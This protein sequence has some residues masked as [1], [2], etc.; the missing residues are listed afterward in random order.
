[1]AR[2]LAKM[3]IDQLIQLPEGKKLEFKRDLSSV[4]PLMKTLVAFAN[5]A[6]GKLIIGIA[7][8]KQVIGVDDPLTE[9]ERLGNLVA[10]SITPRLVPSIEMVTIESKTL[11]IVE[12]YLSNTR[13]HWLTALGLERGVMVRLGSSNRQAGLELIADLQRSVSNQYFDEMP[14][15]ELTVDDLDMDAA[16]QLF[17]DKRDLNQQALL[18]LKLLTHH[19]ARLVPTK[20]A[21]LLFGKQRSFYFNDAWIQCGRFIGKDRTDIFDHIELYDHLPQAADSIIMF[22]KKHAMRGSDFSELRR[23]DVWSIPL[24]ILREVVINAL[25]HADYSQRGMP[26]RVAFY[27]DRIEIESSG[28][29]LPGM[30]V[31]DMKRGTSMIRNPI[32]ARVFRELDLIEQWG[33]GVRGM[34][35]EA[36][37]LGLPEPVIEEVA[38]RVR[39]TVWLAKALPVPKPDKGSRA[40]SGAQSWAQ[41]DQTPQSQSV[42]ICQMLEDQPLSASN[43]LH[44]LGLNSKTGAFKRAIKELLEQGLIEYTIPDKPNSRLQKYRLTDKG[45]KSPKDL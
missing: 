14:M 37:Q 44:I 38:M 22:L 27:D 32:I 30:T 28:L 6:G 3:N 29:L 4:K 45:L 2:P 42:L 10:D 31:E 8:D 21:V 17:A 36:K 41:S 9:E 12:V 39:V 24:G 35:N 26:M 16:Q 25:V 18:S 7:D 33:S 13:P 43:L 23:K 34:Y 19:Q 15:P 11:L 20:G 5:T 1:M 40:Q